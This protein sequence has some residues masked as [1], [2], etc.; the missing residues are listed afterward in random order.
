[1]ENLQVHKGRETIHSLD[2]QKSLSPPHFIRKSP[3]SFLKPHTYAHPGTFQVFFTPH[4]MLPLHLILTSVPH[5][6]LIVNSKST[7]IMMLSLITQNQVFLSE[8][9]NS[10]PL[11]IVQSMQLQHY[12]CFFLKHFH[13]FS[14]Y[15]IYRIMIFHQVTYLGN[16]YLLA[17]FLS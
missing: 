15:T 13:Y 8:L 10:F 4:G 16:H 3:C 1:M 14:T 9:G 17:S 11:L 2:K 12:L 6:P 5:T 7:H